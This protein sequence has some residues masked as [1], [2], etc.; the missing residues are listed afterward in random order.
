MAPHHES[1]KRNTLYFIYHPSASPRDAH[2]HSTLTDR[3]DFLRQYP[4]PVAPADPHAV[5]IQRIIFTISS[6]GRKTIS[7]KN[8]HLKWPPYSREPFLVI[9]ISLTSDRVFMCNTHLKPSA[10]L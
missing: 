10:L 8:S 6:T 2:A 4:F 5:Q 9:D 1:T 3:L 7:I